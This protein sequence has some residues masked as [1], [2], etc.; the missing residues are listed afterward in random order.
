MGDEQPGHLK[1]KTVADVEAIAERYN[2]NCPV[3]HV[4]PRVGQQ[5]F[6]CQN[7]HM[8]C[9]EC[10]PKLRNCPVCRVK[11]AAFS[12]AR[13]R[14]LIAEK[15]LAD[16]P[17]TCRYVKNG[18]DHLCFEENRDGDGY[19]NRHEKYCEFRPIPECPL[20]LVYCEER[21]L[22]KDVE[23][24]AREGHVFKNVFKGKCFVQ[25]RCAKGVRYNEEPVPQQFA[26]AASSLFLLKDENGRGNKFVDV[27]WRREKLWHFCIY[28]LGSANPGDFRYIM[29]FKPA[30]A[31]S[32]KDLVLYAGTPVS[33]D[34]SKE[35]IAAAGNCL[36]LGDDFV[37]NKLWQTNDNKIE[38]RVE[39][40]SVCKK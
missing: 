31:S 26:W 13:T 38:F 5:V 2:L 25:G 6:Q 21:L 23:D 16:L 37:R 29:M 19:N 24:H 20:S 7:G 11:L 39:I 27:V 30:D 36:I 33:V 18:C 34:V 3:C 15:L 40:T 32:D 17:Q 9:G 8:I 10:E 28:Y 14:C 12:G 4:R 1:A 22:F 35:E